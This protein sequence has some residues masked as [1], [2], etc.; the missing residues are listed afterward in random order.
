MNLL[1]FYK[2]LWSRKKIVIWVLLVVITLALVVN[3]LLPKQYVATTSIVIDQRTV[4]PIT[5]IVLPSSQLLPSYMA[6]QAEI[7]GS[8][9][10]A[11]KVVEKL[12]IAENPKMQEDFA[13]TKSV[14]NI[15]DWAAD[16]FLTKLDIK[17]SRESSLIAVSFTA[18]DPQFAALVANAFAQAYIDTSVELRAQPAKLNA[19]WFD[20]QMI[21]MRERLESA[22]AKL[23]SYQQQYGIVA[24]DD[25]LDIENGRLADLSKQLVDS[26][27]RTDE[28]QSRK[29]LLTSTAK[30]GGSSESLQEVLE[31]SL[32]QTLKTQL[33]RSEADFALLSKRLDK[34]HPQYKQAEAEV[35]SL[36]QKLNSEIR[37]IQHGMSSSLASS[38]QRD[39]ILAKSLAEQKSKVLELKKQHDQI[40]VLSHE[41]ENAQKAYDAAMQRTVQTRM[42][43]EMS[44]TNISILNAAI[45]PESPAKPKKLLNMIIAGFLGGVLAI[46]LAL[47][48]ELLDR[49]VRTI[50]DISEGLE[51]PVFAVLQAPAPSVKRQKL[52]P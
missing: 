16:K 21:T 38:K 34:N 48:L 13:Q 40:A 45:P 23:S 33:A 35:N 24:T 9:N 42:E 37:M 46:G 39:E 43:S 17:P 18:I 2:I 6:T 20:T 19:D 41:V 29:N 26:Q 5:G 32:I 12:K 50:F 14:G 49:R 28:L 1:Q 3:L 44:H 51:L 15:T 36:Q 4:D 52:K 10:V 30:E 25:R 8:H 31:S 22:Q 11:R 7:I 27:A 47:V